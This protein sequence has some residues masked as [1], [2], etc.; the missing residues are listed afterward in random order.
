M[1]AV[2]VYHHASRQAYLQNGNGKDVPEARKLTPVGVSLKCQ[3]ALKALCELAL[4]QSQG[5]LARVHEIARAQAIPERFL[6]NILNQL[7]QGGLVASRRGR[8]GGFI[9]ALDPWRISVA[10][11]VTL[12]D[13]AIYG[14]EDAVENS[15]MDAVLGMLWHEAQQAI[16]QVYA[17]KTLLDL[18]NDMAGRACA[19]NYVI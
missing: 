12:I 8:H 19:P 13:G 5:K 14:V 2:C 17:H 15:G 7:R 10:Q 11:V 6:E 18:L 16:T 1:A 4:R 3:Y 9:L